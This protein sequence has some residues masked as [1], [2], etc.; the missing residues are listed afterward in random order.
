MAT[1]SPDTA[2]FVTG[3]TRTLLRF[4]ALAALV[5]ATALFFWFGGNPWLFAILFFAPDLSFIGYGVNA[6]VGALAYNS[7]HS[8]LLPAALGILGMVLGQPLLYQ[9]A[10]ILVAHIGLDRSLGYGLKDASSFHLTH[11][12]PVGR[13]K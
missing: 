6:R 3:T 2:G 7:L 8:Y 13:K 12:G 1:A 11:L 5:V 9:L 4:E 10:L